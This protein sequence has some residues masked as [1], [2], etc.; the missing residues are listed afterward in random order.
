M[1]P[2]TIAMDMLS[3]RTLLGQHLGTR[4]MSAPTQVT[5]DEQQI[6]GHIH[7]IFRAYL[8]E[9]REAI[10]R[11]HT[12]DWVGFQVSS[13]EMVRGIDSY[14]RNANATL[15]ATTPLGYELL[16]TDISVYGDIAIVHY[17]AS[18]TYLDHVDEEHTVRLRS[19]D[20]Y[21]KDDGHWNQCGSNICRV[22]L[23]QPAEDPSVDATHMRLLAPSE[24]T[25]L[26]EA[27][28]S[29]WR[30]WFAGDTDSLRELA[31]RETIAIDPGPS[32]WAD[33]AEIMRRSKAFIDSGDKLVRLDFPTTQIQAFGPVAIIYTTYLFE[34]ESAE[35][36]RT[37][38]SGRGTE[39]FVKR[40]GRWVNPG[41]HLDSGS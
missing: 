41:W 33:L 39:I 14:M 7:G 5:S 32:D 29:V 16:D 21:R 34:T 13:R 20:I 23:P 15:D 37:T 31:P 18:Y 19:A 8:D 12:Q 4:Q 35:G 25:E 40:D 2:E 36:E 22:P 30:A 38:T 3:G 1:A 28:E 27:R 17:L 10:R 11:T 26:L 9:D 6:L 24:Q